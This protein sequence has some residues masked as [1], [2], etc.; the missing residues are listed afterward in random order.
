MSGSPFGNAPADEEVFGGTGEYTTPDAADDPYGPI[1]VY[2]NAEGVEGRSGKLK[3][4]STNKETTI[5]K[6]TDVT[7]DKG[8]AGPMMVFDVVVTEGKFA[9]RDF[10]VYASFSPKARFKL[11]E[12]Y[13]AIG[14]PVDG[15]WGK[16]KAVGTYVGVNLID[17]EYQDQWSAKIKSLF[18][19]PKG[20]GYRGAA[21]LPS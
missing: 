6:I 16:S 4:G 8:P 2:V 15:P 19:H 21:N 13:Q 12:T 14:L 20:V 1:G 17:E 18:K 7:K 10:K 9:G 3:E 11:V 5:G